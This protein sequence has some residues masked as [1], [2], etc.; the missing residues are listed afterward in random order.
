[1]TVLVGACHP[2]KYARPQE[3]NGQI[4]PTYE[5][6]EG[7][8]TSCGARPPQRHILNDDSVQRIASHFRRTCLR[9][10][11]ITFVSFFIPRTLGTRLNPCFPRSHR[12]AHAVACAGQSGQNTPRPTMCRCVCACASH[13]VTPLYEHG[14]GSDIITTQMTGTENYISCLRSPSDLAAFDL[15]FSH[16]DFLRWGFKRILL[17]SR[18]PTPRPGPGVDDRG[19]GSASSPT[20]LPWAF[21]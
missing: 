8:P 17:P 3:L 21:P 6:M 5:R 10:I 13:E 20:S 14:P 1:M 2:G 15:E 4:H 9:D 19:R 18:G 7:L 16:C 11:M 12:E